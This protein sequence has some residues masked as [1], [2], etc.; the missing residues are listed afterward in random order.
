MNL[1][2]SKNTKL[3]ENDYYINNLT[4]SYNIMF[5]SNEEIKNK[6]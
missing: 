5:M 4:L 1:T 6:L 2:K 3:K